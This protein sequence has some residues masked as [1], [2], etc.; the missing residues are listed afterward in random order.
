MLTQVRRGTAEVATSRKRVEL[1]IEQLQQHV[2]ELAE[3]V[4]AGRAAEQD[5]VAAQVAAR[6]SA[7]ATQLA[8][9]RERYAD[10]GREEKR[11]TLAGQRLQAKVDAFRTRKETRKATWTATEALAAAARAEAMIDDMIAEAERLVSKVGAPDPGSAG[12]PQ[13]TEEPLELSELRPGAPQL[14][15]AR[16]LFTVEPPGTA[17]LLAA[18]TERDWLRVWHA[19][20]AAQSRTRYRRDRTG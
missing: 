3:Q 4:G 18:G 11:L 7:A 5:D 16:I 1:Q 14:I 10:L 20:A 2:S 6:Q 15:V 12:S 8:Q 17:V 13:Q 19:Q 9:L